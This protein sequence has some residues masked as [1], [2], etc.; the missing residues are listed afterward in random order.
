MKIFSEL[1]SDKEDAKGL[2]RRKYNPSLEQG[3]KEE[4]TMEKYPRYNRP[5]HLTSVLG[6]TLETL[7][8]DE[9][10]KHLEK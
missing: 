4:K 7:I 2:Q 3:K 6:K 8:T 10:T 5:V 9:I 1:P